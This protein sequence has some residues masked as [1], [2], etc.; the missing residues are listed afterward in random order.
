MTGD[1]VT[2]HHQA[3]RLPRG[4]G[5]TVALCDELQTAARHGRRH[6]HGEGR[7]LPEAPGHP[8]RA[9]RDGGVMSDEGKGRRVTVTT[10]K[11]SSCGA[12]Y[13][14]DVPNTSN[15]CGKCAKLRN[16]REREEFSA[17]VERHMN[18]RDDEGDDRPRVW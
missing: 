9:A 8:A 12:N 10:Y 13:E 7:R 14:A 4:D 6:P 3:W 5:L 18:E 11:C 2:I 15:T 1:I 17:M 16:K